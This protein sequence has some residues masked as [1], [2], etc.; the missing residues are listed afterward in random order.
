M[1]DVKSIDREGKRGKNGR[2]VKEKIVREGDGRIRGEEII[3][4]GKKES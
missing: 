1:G 3:G 2:E 4:S